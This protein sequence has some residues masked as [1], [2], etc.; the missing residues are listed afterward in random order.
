MFYC[1]GKSDSH[2]IQS[3]WCKIRILERENHA[4]KSVC[5]IMYNRRENLTQNVFT[6]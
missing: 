6:I 4:S 3:D 2:E 5:Y 1:K